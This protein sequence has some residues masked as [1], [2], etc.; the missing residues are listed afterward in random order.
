M[1][2]Q[3][4]VSL[5]VAA[6][7]LASGCVTD[8]RYMTPEG[9]GPWAFA[10]EESTPP[11]FESEDGNVYLIEQRVLLEF[12]E[13]TAEELD[14]ANDVG[15][16]VVPW[17]RLPWLV[18]DDY[19]IQVDY[20]L[21][22]LSPDET[23]TVA[24][25]VNGINEFHEYNPGIQ[26]IDEE[27]VADFSGWERS[28]QLGPGE[29]RS[30]VVREEELD[31]I[32]VDLSTVVN[33]APN[34]NQIV[35]FENQSFNDRRSMM[36]IPDVV[37]GLTGVRLGL[38]SDAPVPVLIEATIRVRDARGV[39]VQGDDEPWAA[40]TPALFGPADAPPPAP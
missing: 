21:S 11:F 27:V 31:E 37:A 38:R 18:R 40:P 23:V 8:E 5:G 22:N 19:R 14:Q 9:G 30:G 4:Q 3:V 16:A 35:Y 32:A 17:G 12:R 6:L 29:R 39:L 36:Y 25:I 26:I 10:I 28:I 33:M 1:R 24:V 7:V 13:P 2:G 34:P 15:D 20:T